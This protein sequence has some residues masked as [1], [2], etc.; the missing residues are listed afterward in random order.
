MFA[1]RIALAIPTTVEGRERCRMYAVNYS[2]ILQKG[3]N[4]SDPSWPTMPC[5]YGWEYNSTEVSYASIAS[6]VSHY[7]D[8]KICQVHF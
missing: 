6:E 7:F 3:I 5:R 2:E 4:I 8:E 1:C